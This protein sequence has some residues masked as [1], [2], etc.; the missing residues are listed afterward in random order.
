MKAARIA[1]VT[2]LLLSLS[3]PLAGQDGEKKDGE[4]KPA[5]LVVKLPQEDAKLWVDE[6]EQEKTG[7]ERVFKTPPLTP[8][9][10]YFYV[11]KAFWEPNNYTKITRTRKAIVE[12]GKETKIDLSVAD[13]KQ[14]D[15]IKIRYVPTPKLFVDKMMQMAKVGEKDVVFDLGCGDGRLVVTAVKKYKAMKGVG[16]DIDPQRIKESNEN[17]KKEGVADKVEFREQD[18]MKIPDLEKATVVTLYL[19]NELNEQLWPILQARLPDGAR[20]VTHR[21][22]FGPHKPEKSEEITAKTDWDNDYTEKI[23]MW[24]VRKPKKDKPDEKKEG[25]KKGDEKKD[26]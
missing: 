12:A 10:R 17:A 4:K 3:V 22:V 9:K 25:D 7:E 21:F 24:T 11:L 26:G 6:E 14:P 2:V 5:T 19:G 15:D 13:P 8:G 20:I 18:V 16:V 1:L 23:H